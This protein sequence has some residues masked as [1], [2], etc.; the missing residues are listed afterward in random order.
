MAENGDVRSVRRMA[1]DIDDA[2][3]FNLPFIAEAEGEA[4]RQVRGLLQ[5]VGRFADEAHAPS[6]LWRDAEAQLQ[7]LHVALLAAVSRGR[8]RRR[9]LANPVQP[10]S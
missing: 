6:P 7:E 5:L 10:I 2:L 1:E 3:E 8:E 9:D 4:W